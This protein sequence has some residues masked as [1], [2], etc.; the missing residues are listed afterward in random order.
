MNTPTFFSLFV[1]AHLI[2]VPYHIN[3]IISSS[4]Q[5]V[6]LILIEIVAKLLLN[7]SKIDILTVLDFPIHEYMCLL[8]IFMFDFFLQCCAVLS[9]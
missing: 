9:M 3:F 7:L 8:I 1:L 4:L 6:F 2:I 5:K